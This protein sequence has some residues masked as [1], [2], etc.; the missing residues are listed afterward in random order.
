MESQTTNRILQQVESDATLP[1]L[2]RS[3]LFEVTPAATQ[4]DDQVAKHDADN[5]ENRGQAMGNI[6]ESTTVGRT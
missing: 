1:S 6:Q 3:I 4:G 5:D 2:E